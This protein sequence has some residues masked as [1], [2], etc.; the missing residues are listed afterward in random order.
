MAEIFRAAITAVDK[1]QDD[2]SKAL[3]MTPSVA[4]RRVILPQ[5]L[6][7][8]IPPLGNEFTLMIKGTSLLSIIGIRELFGT[9]QGLNATTFRTFEL[10]LIAAIWYLLLTSI[11][12]LVQRY[13]EAKFGKQD[14]MLPMNK[15]I[16]RSLLVNRG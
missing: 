3:G 5:A 16:R 11:M 4:M 14:A 13:L 7:F 12:A 8:V 15:V 10:F 6:R 9:L 2:A 1:G